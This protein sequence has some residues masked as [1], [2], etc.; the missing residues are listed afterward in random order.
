MIRRLLAF[1]ALAVPLPAAA[2]PDWQLVWSDEFSG[3]AIDASK[4]SFDV[5]CWG[6]GNNERQC[7]SDRPSNARIVDGALVISALRE[8]VTGPALPASQRANPA[9]PG[10]LVK[11]DYSSARL[12]T[13]G[14]ASWRYGRIEVRASLPQGQGTWPAIWMLPEANT[15]GPWAASGEIDILE[16]VNLGVP[17]KDCPAG[18]ED[19]ILGTLH[20]GKPWPN[21][22]HKGNEVHK[23]AV[24]A[25]FHT[26]AIEWQPD[27]IIWQFDGETYA[28]RK[29]SDWFTSGSTS[30]GAPFDQPFHLILNL[31]FGGGLAESRGLKGVSDS[32]FPKRFLIDWVRVW[33]KP[34]QTAS[35]TPAASTMTAATAAS[36][37]QEGGK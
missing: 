11:R 14:K 24:L 23:P 32:N 6:G 19:T 20:F 2:A 17:C 7:Y 10:E 33:Q 15:Y 36:S 25:G 34:P 30:P 4:W 21:N 3:P 31:A 8:N 16:A 26:Y 37:A 18:K 22:T 29:Q 27:Q 9:K 5:D 1:A 28:V 12:S 35:S 13:H